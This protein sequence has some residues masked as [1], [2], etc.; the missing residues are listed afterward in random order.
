MSKNDVGDALLEAIGNA[1]R[2][3]RQDLGLSQKA[4]AD[5]SNLHPTYVSDNFYSELDTCT[6]LTIRI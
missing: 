2:S 4:L 6:Q 3:K 5:R 1:V